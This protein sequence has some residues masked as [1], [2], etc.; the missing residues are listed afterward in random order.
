MFTCG[1]HLIIRKSKNQ[2]YYYCSFY[3]KDKNCLRYSIN[4]KKIE[5]MVKD[6]IIKKFN[7]E[8]L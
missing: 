1:N 4:K 6:E 7:I 8:Q 2:V 3:I 5:Q